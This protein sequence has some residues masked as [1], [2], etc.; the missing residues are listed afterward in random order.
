[1][2]RVPAFSRAIL[3]NRGRFPSIST[4]TVFN[5][6]IGFLILRTTV[7]RLIKQKAMMN[8]FNA[9]FRTG[10]N[11]VIRATII[12]PINTVT[13]DYKRL[14]THRTLPIIKNKVTAIVSRARLVILNSVVIHPCPRTVNV[15]T[16]ATRLVYYRKIGQTIY[17]D[18]RDLFI[19]DEMTPTVTIQMGGVY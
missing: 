17:R 13:V 1:M 12:R 19:N 7:R 6:R 11:A 10:E 16:T 8:R 4:L 15:T 9:N 18:I 5:M 2:V 3:L 14:H